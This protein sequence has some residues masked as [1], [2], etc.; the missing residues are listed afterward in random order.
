[1]CDP[2]GVSLPQALRKHVRLPS[3]WEIMLY[4]LLALLYPGAEKQCE[5]DVVCGTTT[6][7]DVYMP[8][9][10]LAFMVDGEGHC[11]N[12]H[13]GSKG[14]MRVTNQVSVDHAFNSTVLTQPV[15]QGLKGVLRL[16]FRDTHCW[17]THIIR[18]VQA[19][20][21]P[22]RFVLFTPSYCLLDLFV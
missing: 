13:G 2:T 4:M 11:P 3:Q 17:G 5:V 15:G 18:A 16:H 6:L 19:C 21:Q 22:R 8:A 1:M 12:S 9:C 10:N 20:Q 7:V 14:R